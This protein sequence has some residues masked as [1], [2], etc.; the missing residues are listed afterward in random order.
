MLT[1]T[2]LLED[3]LGV[4]DRIMTDPFATA[5]LPTLAATSNTLNSV[6]TN[7]WPRVSE[8][9]HGGRILR[10]IAMSWLSLHDREHQEL[11][12]GA[13]REIQI[14]RQQLLLSW[15]LFMAIVVEPAA[16]LRGKISSAV[17]REPRL[18]ALFEHQGNARHL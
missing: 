13:L 17:S 5:H 14:I 4:I 8:S 11:D 12:A 2:P 3:L 6:L 7:S 9:T 15:K 1:S 16:D 10:I 18:L